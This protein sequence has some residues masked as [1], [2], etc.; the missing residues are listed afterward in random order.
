LIVAANA[1]VSVWSAW[2]GADTLGAHLDFY[3]SERQCRFRYGPSPLK[4]HTGYWDDRKFYC[5]VRAWVDNETSLTPEMVT[6]Q[7]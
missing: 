4:A 3:N 6:C 2:A 7:C 1:G 5:L